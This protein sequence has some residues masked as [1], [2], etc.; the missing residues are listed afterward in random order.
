MKEPGAPRGTL[1]LM[2][3][4]PN[5][6]R[7]CSRRTPATTRSRPW[8][9]VC[10]A[11]PGRVDSPV[12]GCRHRARVGR[13]PRAVGR[14]SVCPAPQSRRTRASTASSSWKIRAMPRSPSSGIGCATRSSRRSSAPHR[15]SESGAGRS[16]NG[17]PLGAT[18][19]NVL[20]TCWAWWSRWRRPVSAPQGGRVHCR[21][22]SVRRPWCSRRHL[23]SVV[24]RS[25]RCSGPRSQPARAS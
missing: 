6:T 7:P 11:T 9:N 4:R 16:A 17:R 23:P 22:R 1:S 3:G 18:V 13:E 5:S 12:C 25:G 8:S 10:C 15:G 2:P 14:S 20:W 21:D 19:L 24:K